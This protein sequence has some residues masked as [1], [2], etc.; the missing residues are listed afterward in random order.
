MNREEVVQAALKVERWCAEHKTKNDDG[1]SCPF[2][3]FVDGCMMINID[4]P[5]DWN[6]DG[7][8]RTRGMKRD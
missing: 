5:A 3:D 1:C 2:F 8:L 7:F 6:L 4:P